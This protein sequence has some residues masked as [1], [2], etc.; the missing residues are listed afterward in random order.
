MVS[1]KHCND[2]DRDLPLTEFGKD[3]T[4]GDGLY[5]YCKVCRNTRTVASGRKY[6]ATANGKRVNRAAC[7]RYKYG[8][9]LVDY[10]AMLSQQQGACAICGGPQQG[11]PGKFLDVDHNHT[12]GQIRGLLCRQCNRTLGLVKEDTDLLL[13]MV[14][15]LN[16]DKRINK[17]NNKHNNNN[18]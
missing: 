14:N 18:N 4:R 2:C 9:T 6:R 11:K 17:H 15:Y 7:L 8:I 12:T 5:P 16:E 1:T 3:R 13:R 10:E